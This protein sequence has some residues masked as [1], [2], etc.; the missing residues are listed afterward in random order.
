MQE[1]YDRVTT[2]L[3]YFSG[4]SQINPEIL[5]R[6]ADRGTRVHN[7]C[8]A[9]ISGLG[10]FALDDDI[11]GYVQSFEQ[12]MEGKT[13]IENP[14]RL[15]CNK[16]MITGES[17]GIYEDVSGYTL[18]DLKTP[19]KESKTWRLQGSAYSYLTK[20]HYP[21]RKIEFVKLS[22]DGKKPISFFYEEDFEMF[23]QCLNVYRLF[24]KSKEKESDVDYL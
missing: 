13:F 7:A 15:Y 11:Q 6:A 14:G 2:S 8:D 5:A 4:L 19:A 20:S 22:K 9:I 17:D 23:I 1:D 21:I 16:Y 12:W 3:Y 18:F 24:F 10:N